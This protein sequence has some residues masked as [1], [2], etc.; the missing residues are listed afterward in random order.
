MATQPKTIAIE[1]IF[2]TDDY[3]SQLGELLKQAKNEKIT[4]RV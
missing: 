3:K 2:D 4:R 1:P